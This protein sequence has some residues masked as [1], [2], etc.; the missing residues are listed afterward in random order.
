MLWSDPENEPPEELRDMQD[1]LRRLG[2]LLAL[3]MLLGMIVLGLS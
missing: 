1:M 3:A 2:L